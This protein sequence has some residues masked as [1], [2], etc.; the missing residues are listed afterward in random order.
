MRTG[1]LTKAILTHAAACTPPES[2]NKSTNN[3][4]MKLK[5]MNNGRLLFTGKRRINKM[6][7]YGFTDPIKLT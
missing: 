3:P 4:N 7:G 6:Y 1:G 5:K 2:E